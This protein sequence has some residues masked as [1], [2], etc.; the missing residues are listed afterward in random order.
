[1]LC[2]IVWSIFIC[3]ADTPDTYPARK[4]PKKPNGRFLLPRKLIPAPLPIFFCRF[5]EIPLTKPS[6]Y[7]NI[8]TIAEVRV[9]PIIIAFCRESGTADLQPID[10]ILSIT[11]YKFA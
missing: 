6:F 5:T 7:G 11:F 2:K 1:M 8:V 10:S 3:Q 4:A 9:Y